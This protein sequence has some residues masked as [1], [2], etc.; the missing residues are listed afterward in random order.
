MRT[1]LLSALSGPLFLT[2]AFTLSLA[3]S[4]ARAASLQ[5][6]PP[7]EEE[8][9][10]SGDPSSETTE[11]S[12]EE[13]APPDDSVQKNDQGSSDDQEPDTRD[14]IIQMKKD[15]KKSPKKGVTILPK[16]PAQESDVNPNDFTVLGTGPIRKDITPLRIAVG[17]PE[18][19][20]LYHIPLSEDLEIALGGGLFYGLN[21]TSAGDLFG[22]KGVLEAKWRFW[23]DAEHSLALMAAPSL[24]IQMHPDAALGIF[25]GGPSLI[26]EYT[27]QSKHHAI[28]GLE[29]PWGLFL[30]DGDTSARI[31][32]VFKMG[33]EFALQDSIHLFFTTET[34]ADIWTGNGGDAYF[35]VRTLGGLAIPL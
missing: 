23:R 34:G 19:E 3:G 32:M 11:D 8:E 27:I 33:L 25:V 5:S 26:Y 13:E 10:E 17:Y 18:V 6:D 35:F 20:A 30:H 21:A 15:E 16:G 28:L 24:Y 2:L 7:D 9:Y 1:R 31:P 22:P 14:P 29:F 4:P 12:T